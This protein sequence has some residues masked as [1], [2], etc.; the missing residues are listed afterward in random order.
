METAKT[1]ALCVLGVLL[2][3]PLSL[4]FA[5]TGDGSVCDGPNAAWARR[6]V[7]IALIVGYTWKAL[8]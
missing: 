4:V 6:V 8:R 5:G 1:R 7:T 2:F 3:L